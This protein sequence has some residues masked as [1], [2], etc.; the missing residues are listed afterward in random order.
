MN[1]LPPPSPKTPEPKGTATS[2]NDHASESPLELTE[3]VEDEEGNEGLDFEITVEEPE[4]QYWELESLLRR[5]GA[6][7]QD[8]RTIA[9]HI[10]AK[11]IFS[12]A[13]YKTTCQLEGKEVDQRVLKIRDGIHII[14]KGPRP[15]LSLFG[16]RHAN[17][18]HPQWKEMAYKNCK[19]VEDFMRIS[20]E[21]EQAFDRDNK[22]RG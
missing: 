22:K 1:K 18:I 12:G 16:G 20:R 4:N 13:L 11:V 21:M 6:S 3:A 2:L 10:L 19:R 9:G 17:D 7:I 14:L 15:G 8:Y 5:W